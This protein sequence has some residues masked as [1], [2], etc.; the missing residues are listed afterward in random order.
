MYKLTGKKVRENSFFLWFRWFADEI[1][2]KGPWRIYGLVYNEKRM[3]K[4]LSKPFTFFR[5]TYFWKNTN[6]T[7]FVFLTF[8]KVVVAAFY[9]LDIPFF[10]IFSGF[11][12]LYTFSSCHFFFAYGHLCWKI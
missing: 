8:P 11:I 5:K 1:I 2:S 4:I 10:T 6:F 7:C 3:E 12:S 9:F